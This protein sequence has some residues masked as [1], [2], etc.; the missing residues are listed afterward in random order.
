M[1]VR[2]PALLIALATIF[3]FSQE[4][5]N[6]IRFG[7]RAAMASNFFLINEDLKPVGDGLGFSVGAAASIP[8]VSTITFN[9]EL[10]LIWRGF[11]MFYGD[12]YANMNEF[13]ISIPALFQYM[14]FG[15]PVFYLE[16]GIQ[17]DY[18]FVRNEYRSGDYS[19]RDAF[20]G[21]P[22]GL[23]WHI[24]KHFVIDCRITFDLFAYGSYDNVELGLLQSELS[25]LYLF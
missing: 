16:A 10:N 19:Y 24:G 4:Q 23:G 22:F 8:I 13:A 12:D 9:P 6:K 17:L 11:D 21:I 5:E 1:A 2:I 15:G 7:A 25:L 3:S 20:L 18:P 14:S